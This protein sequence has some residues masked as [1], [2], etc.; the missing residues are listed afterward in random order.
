MNALSEYFR[1]PERYARIA[2]S[3][4]PSEK[5]GYFRFCE[6]TLYGNC[7]GIVPAASA[8][9]MAG[10]AVDSVR[11][12]EGTTHLPFDLDQVVDNLRDELY[13]DWWFGGAKSAVVNLYYLLRPFLPVAV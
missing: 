6:E 5:K 2:L 1:C 8:D 3:G 11:M 12:E 13:S 10:N 7:S 4:T 9:A